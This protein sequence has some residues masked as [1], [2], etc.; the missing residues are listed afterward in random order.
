MPEGAHDFC[1]FMESAST[2]DNGYRSFEDEHHKPAVANDHS[3]GHSSSGIQHSISTEASPCGD[4]PRNWSEVYALQEALAPTAR[5]FARVT[6]RQPPSTSPW[7]SYDDQVVT[8]QQMSDRLWR[9]ERRMGEPPKL[10]RLESWAGG[11]R[12]ITTAAILLSEEM[13]EGSEH[14]SLLHN[15]CNHSQHEGQMGQQRYDMMEAE[16]QHGEARARNRENRAGS[17]ISGSLSKGGDAV[18]NQREAFRSHLD[19]VVARDLDKC[20]LSCQIF[21]M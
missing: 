3:L 21:F 10:A 13:V 18:R 5:T 1:D 12:E 11:I 2:K 20:K 4:K 17:T 6:G 16:L 14:P 19:A 7:D 15:Q 9:R 8:L